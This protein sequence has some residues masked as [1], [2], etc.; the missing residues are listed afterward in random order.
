MRDWKEF[1]PL[2][3]PPNPSPFFFKKLSNKVIELFSLPLLY[4]PFFKL[5]NRPYMTKCFIYFIV[6]QNSK[7]NTNP[8][9][10]KMPITWVYNFNC[11]HLGISKKK[12]KNCTQLRK[13]NWQNWIQINFDMK[14]KWSTY[15]WLVDILGVVRLLVPNL[16]R[17]V[18]PRIKGIFF[19]FSLNLIC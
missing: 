19:F 2:Q 12:K 9:S 10:Q 17:P 3:T 13:L 14:E 15:T 1:K 11:T 8:H 6:K 16:T 4:S 18:F 5:P 7:T